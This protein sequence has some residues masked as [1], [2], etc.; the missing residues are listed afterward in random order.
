MSDRQQFG[1]NWTIEKLEIFT[2]Y[3]DAYLIA[4]KNMKF[5][6][7]Y[8]DA[9]AGTGAITTR[10]ESQVLAGSAKRALMAADKF[11][12]YYFIEADKKKAK[13]L[14][15]MIET[16]FPELRHLT[17][18]YCGDANAQLTKIIQNINWRFSRALLFLDPCATEVNWATLQAVAN[19]KSIDV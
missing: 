18:G 13:K 3:L 7:I 5:K 12:H 15:K 19:T 8:I 11:D 16:E 17:T 6:K 10:D 2:G 4:L 1:G 14:E 9:F